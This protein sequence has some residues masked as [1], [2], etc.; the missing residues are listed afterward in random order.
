[1][2]GIAMLETPKMCVFRFYAYIAPDE[3]GIR[4]VY[5][6]CVSCRH[7]RK[8]TF[9]KDQNILCE[10][11]RKF[12]KPNDLYSVHVDGSARHNFVYPRQ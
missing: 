9:E 11:I 6:Q 2:D 3:K 8:V 1:M 4:N 5:T 10:E 7:K 12:L